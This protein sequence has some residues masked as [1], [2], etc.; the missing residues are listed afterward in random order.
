M[1]TISLLWKA[2]FCW[3]PCGRKDKGLREF[4]RSFLPS[5]RTFPPLREMLTKCACSW[6]PLD[7]C[8]IAPT[9]TTAPGRPLCSAGVS[10][11]LK[12]SMS[13]RQSPPGLIG[14]RGRTTLCGKHLCSASL[15]KTGHVSS[16][17]CRRLPP[18]RNG[19]MSLVPSSVLVSGLTLAFL[20]AEKKNQDA[21]SPCHTAGISLPAASGVLSGAGQRWAK[22]KRKKEKKRE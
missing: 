12:E 21:L 3:K 11:L 20:Q 5:S 14:P 10:L 8:Q 6:S 17:C 15:C 13:G 1:A 18:D 19:G 16:F 22:G 7:P 9:T 4:P 2:N